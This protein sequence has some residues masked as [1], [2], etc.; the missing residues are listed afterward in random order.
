[1]NIPR[2]EGRVQAF[3]ALRHSRYRWFLTSSLWQ[4]CAMGMQQLALSWMVLQLTG[5]VAQLGLV[6]FLQGLPGMVL[7]VFAGALADRINRK[8]LLVV[9]QILL[10]GIILILASLYFSGVIQVWHIYVGGVLSGAVQAF[11]MPVRTAIVRDLVDRESIMN[12]VSLNNAIGMVS[13]I[14]APAAAGFIIDWVGI[15]PSLVV[16]AGFYAAGVVCQLFMGGI[17]RQSPK[18]SV[19]REVIVGM[20]FVASYPQ[21]YTFI[22]L[23]MTMGFF[24]QPYMQ[25]TPAYATTVLGLGARGT[26]MLLTAGG[27]GALCGSLLLASLGDYRHKERLL[28]ITIF[29]YNA[30]LFLFSLVPNFALDLLILPVVGFGGT[31]F[32]ALANIMLQLKTP[33]ELSGRV[34]SIWMIGGSLVSVGALPMGMVASELGIRFALGGGALISMLITIA[35][36]FLYLRT[37]TREAEKQDPLPLEA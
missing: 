11:N 24:G 26:G 30:S 35:L 28:W 20:K 15:G 23:T 10:T 22:L 2:S 14:V 13:R 7:M 36:G 3:R 4:A 19:G 16:N 18:G 9:S 21:L 32:L 27:V 5:S 17:P 25:L 8:T 34:L 31:T 1:M 33:P 29:L 6:V 37:R 12:A